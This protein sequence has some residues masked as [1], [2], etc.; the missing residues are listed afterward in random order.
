M[1]SSNEG[2]DAIATLRARGY[3]TPII[4][5]S[6]R[7]VLIAQNEGWEEMKDGVWYNAS[8]HTHLLHKPYG[9]QDLTALLTE[10][11]QPATA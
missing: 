3:A 7:G 10:I 2:L 8:M 5:N 6:G 4:L 1:P 9:I 11:A